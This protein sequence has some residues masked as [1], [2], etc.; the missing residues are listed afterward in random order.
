MSHSPI[1]VLWEVCPLGDARY[2]VRDAVITSLGE[3]AH[4]SHVEGESDA[5]L[6][7][8][9]PSCASPGADR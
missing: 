3:K 4:A 7:S 6:V 9:Q 5:W 2:G 1:R 8:P